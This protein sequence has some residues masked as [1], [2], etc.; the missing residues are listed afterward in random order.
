[1]QH[2]DPDRTSFHE[3]LGWQGLLAVLYV[4]V[5]LLLAWMMWS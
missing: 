4:G 5:A 3:L 1:M 2:L